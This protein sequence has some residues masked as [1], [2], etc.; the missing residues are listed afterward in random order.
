VDNDGLHSSREESGVVALAA[1]L[2]PI[3][4]TMFE[5]SGGFGLE[6]L[7]SGPGV[8]RQPI[9]AGSLF[10]PAGSAN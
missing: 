4:V 9:P 2:H 1:G 7:F 3:T 8:D 10:R 6:V 5:Q